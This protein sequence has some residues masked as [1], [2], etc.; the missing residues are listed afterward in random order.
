MIVIAISNKK[1]EIIRVSFK[2]HDYT[3]VFDEID[4]NKVYEHSSHDYAIKTKRNC[5]FRFYL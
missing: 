1:N 2:Y 5:F 4:V 3:D